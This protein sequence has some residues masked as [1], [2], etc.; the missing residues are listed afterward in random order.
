LTV[1]EG[2][3]EL[4]KQDGCYEMLWMALEVSYPGGRWEEL[5]SEAVMNT[6][7]DQE[8]MDSLEYFLGSYHSSIYFERDYTTG[9][10]NLFVEIDA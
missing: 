1:I 10:A 6:E 7:Y 2:W 3:E 5:Q 9:F 8:Y 4:K